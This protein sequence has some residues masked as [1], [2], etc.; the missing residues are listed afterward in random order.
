MK[1]SVSV[2]R[3]VQL[4]C[5]LYFAAGALAPASAQTAA[6]R[7]P[8]TPVVAAAPVL[9]EAQRRAGCDHRDA[10]D[11]GDLQRVV[12]CEQFGWADQQSGD[13]CDEAGA[14]VGLS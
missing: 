6:D 14:G 10:D 9:T 11:G 1:I 12:D 13:L 4:V 8:A 7:S 5:A 3:P 2:G